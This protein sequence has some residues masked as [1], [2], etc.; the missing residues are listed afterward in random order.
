MKITNTKGSGTTAIKMIV[1]GPAG[2]GKTTLAGT[3]K[4]NVLIISA[5][6][7]LL[8]LAD[9]S[10][11][12]F[13][14]AVDDE[15]K[16]VPKEN[17][18]ARLGE[19]FAYLNTDEAKKKYQW[20]FV[21][22]LTEIGQNLVEKLQKEYTSKSDTLKLWGDYATTMRS[23]I[24]SFRDLAGYNVV[25]TALELIDKDEN[26]Q[27]FSGINLQGKIADHLPGFFDVVLYLQVEKDA[28]GKT[29]RRLIS[30]KSE[31]NVC[32]DRSGKL[33]PAEPCDLSIIAG[34]INQKVEK[35]EK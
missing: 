17:R 25:F 6:A 32:K 35:K 12:V 5:E 16:Q 26:N 2:A 4:E 15:G 11:D 22:S 34:K 7:G 1:Y 8:C 30:A 27:R 19:V 28:E 18:I 21:D 13:D 31:K 23:M 29:V 33:L 14:I 3:I 9:K 10:L 20:V 24:K